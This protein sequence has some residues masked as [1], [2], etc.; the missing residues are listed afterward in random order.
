MKNIK[1]VSLP[2]FNQP[3]SFSFAL[4]CG[5]KKSDKQKRKRKLNFGPS[6]WS[7]NAI[8]YPIYITRSVLCIVSVSSR[9]LKIYGKYEM[10][11]FFDVDSLLKCVLHM[12]GLFI[13]YSFFLFSQTNPLNLEI[14]SYHIIECTKKRSTQEENWDPNTKELIYILS[15]FYVY[16]FIAGDQTCSYHLAQV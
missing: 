3:V 2:Y 14:R 12:C 10:M 9:L 15:T 4:P 5:R 8:S 11:I 16:K 6:W 13:F 1:L 7:S